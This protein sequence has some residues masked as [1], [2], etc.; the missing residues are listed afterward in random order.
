MRSARQIE[1]EKMIDGLDVNGILDRYFGKADTFVLISSYNRSYH[2]NE[3]YGQKYKEGRVKLKKSYA[4]SAFAVWETWLKKGL[5]RI[6]DEELS[7]ELPPFETVF[8]EIKA[9]S[10]EFNEKRIRGEYLV[11]EE[12]C[13]KY[14][15]EFCG[16]YTY[17][18]SIYNLYVAGETKYR[19]RNKFIRSCYLEIGN[20]YADD[21][22]VYAHLNNLMANTCVR[23]LDHELRKPP[24]NELLPHLIKATPTFRWHCTLT[25]GLG[26]EFRFRF[27]QATRAWLAEHYK[28]GPRANGYGFLCKS[29]AYKYGMEDLAFYNGDKLL[30]SQCSHE[31]MQSDYLERFDD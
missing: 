16:D 3:P 23:P 26:K 24:F 7:A 17:S 31:S 22:N 15:C 10:I 12:L 30:F 27:N 5:R 29:E 1:H 11:T 21:D 14:D 13:K 9:E 6:Y 8:E 20:I 25:S 19:A 18:L 2:D 4:E 28:F